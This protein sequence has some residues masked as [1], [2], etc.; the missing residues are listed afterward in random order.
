MAVTTTSDLTAAVL[1][2]YEKTYREI[3]YSKLSYFHLVDWEGMGKGTGSTVKRGFNNRLDRTAY[4][5]TEGQDGTPRLAKDMSWVEI[6]WVDKYDGIQYDRMNELKSQV[7]VAKRVAAQIASNQAAYLNYFI[8]EKFSQGTRVSRLGDVAT[9]VLLATTSLP[10]LNWLIEL[11]SQLAAMKVEP[12]DDG[13]Y[14]ANVHPLGIGEVQKLLQ[15]VAQYSD[16]GMLYTGKPSS[17]PRLPNESFRIGNIRFV[18]DPDGKI[19]IGAGAATQA[20]TTLTA[21]AADGA[22]AIAVTDA[23]GLAVG[24]YITIGTLESSSTSRPTT[25]QVKITAVSGTDLTIEGAGNAEDNFG[26]MYDHA[27]GISVIE[28]ANVI[29]MD[30]VGKNS[31]FGIYEQSMGKEGDQFMKTNTATFLPD[32]LSDVGWHWVGGATIIQKR[33]LRAEFG[34]ALKFMGGN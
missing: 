4:D 11:E 19:F 16:P 8:R 23:T 29:G 24:N 20:A 28:S 21:D 25:E 15:T 14:V 9:R 6:S 26:L 10:T 18:K 13:C 17:G 5:R 2:A 3:L 1:T 30:I 22:T 33:V 7:P 12:F 32:I 34:T 27:S 31:M